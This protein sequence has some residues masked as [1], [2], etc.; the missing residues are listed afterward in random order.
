MEP[1]T[2]TRRPSR[3]SSSVNEVPFAIGSFA[4]VRY[5]GM[6]PTHCGMVWSVPWYVAVCEP[7]MTGDTLFTSGAASWSPSAVT[8]LVVSAVFWVCTVIPPRTWPDVMVSVLVPSRSMF[9]W[10]WR[11]VPLPTAS[12]IE[13]PSVAGAMPDCQMA[14]SLPPEDGVVLYVILS[15]NVLAS[16]DPADAAVL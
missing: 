6:V 10:I 12:Q 14:P 15:A 13:V 9:A 3:T 4:A 1:S 8:R 5:A 7:V 11:D 2:T 16:P